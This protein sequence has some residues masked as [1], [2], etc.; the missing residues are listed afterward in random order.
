M[1]VLVSCSPEGDSSLKVRQQVLV[2]TSGDG[3]NRGITTYDLEGNL[4]SHVTD[5]RDETGTPRGIAQFD[6]ESFLVS[7]DGIDAIYR[8][9]YN[10][11][12]E[13]FHGSNN[14]NG[15]IYGLARG[16]LDYY[17][18]VESNRIEV[19]DSEGVRLTASLINTTTGGCTLSN[20]R[21]I[22]ATDNGTLIVVNNGAD[23]IL[24]YD[25]TTAVATCN[26]AV[27]FSNN[28]YGILVHSNGS[29]YISTQGDD[30]VHRA[31]LD[32]SGAVSI[33]DPGTAV[34]E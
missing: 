18:A 32:G 9:F 10:G 21:L 14:L 1:F 23:R 13:F 19:F 12:K 5:L 6:D 24:T 27:G 31:N 33:F 15:A 28:P 11:E 29:L 2:V 26:T 22:T 4:I 8:V 34:S 17:Y 16:P 25:I 20:P 30:A 3:N 7:A